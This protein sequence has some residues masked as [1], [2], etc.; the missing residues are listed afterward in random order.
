MCLVTREIKL[1]SELLRIVKTPSGIFVD[2]EGNLK[3]RGAYLSKDKKVIETA[4]KKHLLNK[5]LRENVDES[6]YDE[7]L[8]LL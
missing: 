7:L 6:I 2:K 4:K 1:R 5:A 3:G 8:N